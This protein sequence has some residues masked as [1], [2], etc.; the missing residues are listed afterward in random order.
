MHQLIETG[1]DLL[2][3]H[4]HTVAIGCTR[5]RSLRVGY[6]SMMR[7]YAWQY[8]CDSAHLFAPSIPATVAHGSTAWVPVVSRANLA[9][10]ALPA[11]SN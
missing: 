10:V 5:C 2:L 7:P 11:I 3:C 4:H 1:P 8:V 9:L 6:A